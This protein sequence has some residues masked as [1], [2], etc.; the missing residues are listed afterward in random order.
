[1]HYVPVHH[2]PV[3]TDIDLPPGGLPECESL[4]AR[5]L[6]LPVFPDLTD[7]QVDHVASVLRRTVEPR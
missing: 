6:S 1:V 2:H 7:E 3:S 5:L 4:Y